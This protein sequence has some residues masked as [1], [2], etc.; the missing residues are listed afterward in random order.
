MFTQMQSESLVTSV[1]EWQTVPISHGFSPFRTICKTMYSNLKNT[2]N[3]QHTLKLL[4]IYKIATLFY[5]RTQHILKTTN[6][7]PRNHWCLVMNASTGIVSGPKSPTKFRDSEPLDQRLPSTSFFWRLIA[8]ER[9]DLQ[10]LLQ[11]IMYK[12]SLD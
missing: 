9:H 2:L 1:H 12:W 3:K 4:R 5:V 6:E 8:S 7:P 10:S 11:T